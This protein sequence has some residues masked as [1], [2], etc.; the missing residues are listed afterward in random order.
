MDASFE[1]ESDL[2]GSGYCDRPYIC[3][4]NLLIAFFCVAG[5]IVEETVFP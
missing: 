1:G 2:V 3:Q 5:Q 4:V